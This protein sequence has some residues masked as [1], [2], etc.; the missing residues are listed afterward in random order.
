M[1]LSIWNNNNSCTTKVDICRHSEMSNFICPSFI[2][3]HGP[4]THVFSFMSEHIYRWC[5]IFVVANFFQA[6]EIHLIFY[7]SQHSSTDYVQRFLSLLVF[8][9][10]HALPKRVLKWQTFILYVFI[11]KTKKHRVHYHMINTTI[12]STL[13]A[14]WM[15]KKC[16]SHTAAP[17][18]F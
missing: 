14:V 15:K 3:V 7:D 16:I 10:Y 6:N 11:F 17:N 2:R 18:K 4:N 9:F 8:L 12:H 13:F 1:N 5:L